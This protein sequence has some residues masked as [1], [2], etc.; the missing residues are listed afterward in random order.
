M[1]VLQ[2]Q[3]GLVHLRKRQRMLAR[4]ATDSQLVAVLG[5]ARTPRRRDLR[6][7]EGPVTTHSE[8][9]PTLSK[10][11]VLFPLRSMENAQFSPVR[12]PSCTRSSLS[13]CSCHGSEWCRYRIYCACLS[14]RGF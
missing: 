4:D 7:R 2:V 14:S 8:I 9:V 3:G 12:L 11:S 6:K 1:V 5:I 10:T 13:C